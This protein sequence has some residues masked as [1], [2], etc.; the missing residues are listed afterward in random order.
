MASGIGSRHN[1]MGIWTC[2]ITYTF[3]NDDVSRGPCVHFFPSS[4]GGRREFH[5]PLNDGMQQRQRGQGER[6]KQKQERISHI[7]QSRL[8]EFE[9]I[10]LVMVEEMS[11]C[12]GHDN[13]AAL[14]SLVNVKHC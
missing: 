7:E 3:L 12:K 4:Q 5:I 13:K 8:F 2:T 6:A 11:D 9:G 1:S 10:R 14:T